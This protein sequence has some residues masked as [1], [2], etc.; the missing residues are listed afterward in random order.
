MI[1][2]LLTAGPGFSRWDPRPAS[3]GEVVA[4]PGFLQFCKFTVKTSLQT[5]LICFLYQKSS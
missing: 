4:L 3:T 5:L 1:C 2:L